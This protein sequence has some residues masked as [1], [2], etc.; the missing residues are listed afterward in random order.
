MR[1]IHGIAG[2]VGLQ[3]PFYRS[4]N[5]PSQPERSLVVIALIIL[6]GLASRMPS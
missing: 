3:P 5:D 4:F 2:R 1:D 6:K